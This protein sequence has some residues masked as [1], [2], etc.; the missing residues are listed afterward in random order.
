ML[1]SIIGGIS[2]IVGGLF[3][4]SSADKANEA[5]AAAHAAN[6]QLQK[7]FAQQGIRWKVDD[8]KAAGIHPL[9]ALGANTVS[10]AP[11]ALGQVPDTS[12]PNAMAAAGQDLSRAIDQTRTTPERDAAVKA[13][14]LHLDG[15][16]LDNDIK[17]ATIASSM[18]RLAQ[19]SRPPIPEGKVEARPPLFMG[20]E[21]METHPGT[22]NTDDYSKRYGE[23][24]EWFYAPQVWWEDFKYRNRSLPSAT[25]MTRKKFG[26]P[27]KWLSW[28]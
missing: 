15:L 24:G 6:I 7:D 17:R 18:Q 12:L 8:A 3:G 22:S 1:G 23:P 14:A 5:N 10:F 28:D 21:K 2:N 16:A 9:Y 11:Q 4:K 27:P 25:E 20:G 13:T 26:N 19:Q